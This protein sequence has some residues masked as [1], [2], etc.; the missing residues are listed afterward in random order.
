MKNRYGCT[1]VI[2]FDILILI[3]NDLII[4]YYLST[5]LITYAFYENQCIYIFVEQKPL[6]LFF[7]YEKIQ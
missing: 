6:L 7:F 4:S 2:F 1:N 3:V 5:Y